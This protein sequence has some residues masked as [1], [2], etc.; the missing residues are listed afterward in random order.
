MQGCAHQKKSQRGTGIPRLWYLPGPG[1]SLRLISSFKVYVGWFSCIE[2]Q[3]VLGKLSKGFLG[4]S[5]VARTMA[6]CRR[7]C[8]Q[9]LS[10]QRPRSNL[11]QDSSDTKLLWHLILRWRVQYHRFQLFFF[12]GANKNSARFLWGRVESVSAW[13]H[14]LQSKSFLGCST[15]AWFK[16]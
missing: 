9:Y 2:N 5:I 11:F 12:N 1:S 10:L 8:R 16:S 15:G 7:A 13:L 3:S 14:V 4:S 6:L